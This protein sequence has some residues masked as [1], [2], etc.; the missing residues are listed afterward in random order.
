MARLIG[1][2]RTLHATQ[3]A[4]AHTHHKIRYTT[5][6]D[7]I[8]PRR[9]TRGLA[10]SMLLCAFLC[11]LRRW[12][13]W[14][15]MRRDFRCNLPSVDLRKIGST[16]KVGSGD[17]HPPEGSWASSPGNRRSMQLNK[18]RDTKP[19]LAVRSLLHAAGLRYRVDRRPLPDF[20]RR[21]DIVFGPAKVAVF[22]D[23]CYWHG[24]PEHYQAPETNAGYWS[25]KIEANMRR[26]RETGAT[27]AAEG[28][29]ALRFWEHQDPAGCAEQIRSAVSARRPG[30]S[31]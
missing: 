2:E 26:G 7:T 1:R 14:R 17:W 30:N 8:P 20:P 9:M 23:G 21:A 4:P 6:W 12:P 29:L 22:I 3:R 5:R 28:W 27:L 15:L 18:G 24:C 11:T 19:E 31:T 10:G 16:R 13:L 25:P